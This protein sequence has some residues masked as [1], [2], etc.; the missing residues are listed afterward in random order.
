MLVRI[1]KHRYMNKHCNKVSDAFKKLMDNVVMPYYKREFAIWQNFRQSKLWCL[2]IDDLFRSNQELIN[3]LWIR[4]ATIP[5]H[6]KTYIAKNTVDSGDI[7]TLEDIYKMVKDADININK[8][9]VQFSFSLSK[10][11]VVKDSEEVGQLVLS[12]MV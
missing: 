10:Q 5:S 6:K 11:T 3:R 4:Y 7:L 12:R 2:D 8:H 1:A 9:E